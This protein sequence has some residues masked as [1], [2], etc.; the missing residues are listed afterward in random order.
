MN[1]PLL[2]ASK[3]K[4]TNS[5]VTDA[6][7]PEM[8]IN[9]HI[10][11]KLDTLTK[12]KDTASGHIRHEQGIRNDY[13]GRAPF[14]LLQNAIDRAD[15]KVVLKLC[16]ASATFTVSNDGRPFS[17]TKPDTELRSDLAAL[18]AVNA[19]NKLAGESI[20]NK[21]VG[22]RSVWQFCN[23]IKIESRLQNNPE[24]TWGFRFYFPFNASALESWSD[25]PLVASIEQGM[26]ALPGDEH[27]KAPS[28]YFPEY[29]S[30]TENIDLDMVTAITLEGLSKSN[31][32]KLEA[33]LL[34][35]SKY[36]LIFASF[37]SF[38]ASKQNK[39]SA[40][41]DI[42]GV[43]S[44]VPLFPDQ[45]DY[46]IEK[47]KTA[48]I[49]PLDS[50]LLSELDYKL[51][52]SPQLFLAI[53]KTGNHYSDG[54]F[55][56]YLPTE[57][58]TGCPVHIHGDFFADSSRKHIDVDD[59]EYNRKLLNL[60]LK[61][62]LAVLANNHQE[63]SIE[64]F[65]DAL[66]PT[67]ILSDELKKYLSGGSKLAS[68]IEIMLSRDQ[69]PTFPEINKIYQLIN[70]YAP[71]R[72][73]G[74]HHDKHE[75][76]LANYYDHFSKKTIKIVPL[77]KH[78]EEESLDSV[79]EC[80]S[81]PEAGS[82]QRE[83]LFCLTER[84]TVKPIHASGVVVTPW[85]FPQQIAN[86]LNK[87]SVW[88][89]YSDVE[90]VI[91]AIRR[92]Q[93]KTENF[94]ER[95]RLLKA[96]SRLDLH[97]RELKT[98]WRF[99][100]RLPH[101]VQQLRV[102]TKSTNGWE[103]ASECYFSSDFL[104]SST[105]DSEKFFEID[106]DKAQEILG[107][108]YKAQLLHWGA[109]NVLPLINT[110]K[111]N[112]PIW[113]LSR[114]ASDLVIGIHDKASILHF[115]A[116]SFS[117]WVA[118]ARQFGELN[119]LEYRALHRELNES[120]WLKVQTGIFTPPQSC[121]VALKH[122]RYE[123]LPCIRKT[124]L[125]P[126]EL[127]LIEWLNVR[128][129]EDVVDSKKLLSAA[130]SIAAKLNIKNHRSV[131][132]EYKAVVKQL[133][134][135]HI[136]SKIETINSEFPRLVR[137]KNTIRVAGDNEPVYFF[138]S[139]ERRQI[140]NIRRFGYLLWEVNRETSVE[141]AGKVEGVVRP[142]LRPFTEPP[143]ETAIAD[144][145]AY[146]FIKYELLPKLFAYAETAEEINIDPDGDAIRMRWSMVNIYRCD[147]M[148][149]GY[150]D[151]NQI[152][153][154]VK[155]LI[156][157]K[158]LSVP[159]ASLSSDKRQKPAS[160]VLHRDFNLTNLEHQRILTSWFAKEIF[161]LPALQQ[162][163]S[164]MLQQQGNK[165]DSERIAEY[166]MI[167]S[168][169]ISESDEAELIGYLQSLTDEDL[170]NGRWRW[171]EPY[172]GKGISYF[173]IKS[174]VPSDWHWL[175]E[176]LNPFDQNELSLSNWLSENLDKLQYIRP[177]HQFSTQN[178]VA[179]SSLSL[180]DFDPKFHALKH[181]EIPNED[182]DYLDTTKD[183]EIAKLTDKAQG[184]FKANIPTA[185]G[186]SGLQVSSGVGRVP[187]G[188]LVKTKDQSQ[189]DKEAKTK[190]ESGSSAEIQL[191]SDYAKRVI[192]MTR[193]QQIRVLFGIKE[194]FQRLTKSHKV[195][196]DIRQWLDSVI[197]MELP[198]TEKSWYELLH[199]GQKFDGCGYDVIGF[200]LH[201]LS[202]ILVE[203]KRSSLL[204]NPEIFFSENERLC[205]IKLSSKQFKEMYPNITW[206]LFLSHGSNETKD[207]TDIVT[208]AIEDHAEAYNLL[209]RPL[210]ADGWKLSLSQH[211]KNT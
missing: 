157:E 65:C 88:T 164:L 141:L 93:D 201:S 162:G 148:K 76:D 143:I 61:N 34:K 77:R 172:M 15:E 19:S 138:S 71:V 207:V 3:E 150:L 117:V 209:E 210:I 187:V 200:N 180:I 120:A 186:N 22:F 185:N 53:P 112:A 68:L 159:H 131:S 25:K 75:N 54:Y 6:I 169:W 39:M 36:P 1:T 128:P 63:F 29:L 106:E 50:P 168:D 80:V 142:K 134:E 133:N 118:S 199:V 175:I 203:V 121:F 84:S 95:A 135:P 57:M 184:G 2:N 41:F 55:H 14:E 5:V 9:D 178:V 171:F 58:K 37:I 23:K 67:G 190:A 73:Y 174:A 123:I 108:E 110:N 102:P 139:E 167:V 170:T 92:A 193:N 189:R 101:P 153:A 30:V 161:D 181:L 97:N 20:G 116:E 126:A 183:L 24:K 35:I 145:N 140:K 173:D 144:L 43:R 194:E 48:E 152:Q 69:S 49:I 89:E 52:Q 47:V 206:K 86:D 192:Q 130:H 8:V 100:G 81:L 163:F 16:R 27:G 78:L 103:A 155:E 208:H 7:S 149:A 160:L 122:H 154:D 70:T 82:K 197:D 59:N 114:S 125:S 127:T 42:C 137:E 64:V 45:K 177:R 166:Q 18:C 211:D 51:P 119:T 28:F 32:D 85:R 13:M 11:I 107:L 198:K 74:G 115:L 191:A 99:S 202:L 21:G 60:A 4:V 176:S 182:F 87:I 40:I 205:F 72:V 147:N 91:R 195:N 66:M 146:N 83:R 46:F 98:N 156:H 113:Q 90:A 31:L 12:D 188:S 132:Q 111:E 196:S 124:E 96:A 56:C 105:V 17:Y 79:P 136:R 26:Y 204:L 94:E 10:R 129:L 104:N 62:L 38:E 109:W 179:S 44:E 151:S 158:V 165:L 33:L